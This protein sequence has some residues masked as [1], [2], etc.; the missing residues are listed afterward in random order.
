MNHEDGTDP[1]VSQRPEMP[2]WDAIEYN[3][4]ISAGPLLPLLEQYAS[5]GTMHDQK[6]TVDMF[7]DFKMVFYLCTTMT[8]FAGS[9]DTNTQAGVPWQVGTQG[10][11]GDRY[12]GDQL[13]VANVANQGNT[14]K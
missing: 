12:T 13:Q 4:L 1:W 3:Q 11:I 7:V 8:L 9:Y 6:R 14:R 10:A 2:P 5:L